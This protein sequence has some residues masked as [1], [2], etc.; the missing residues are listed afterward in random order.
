MFNGENVAFIYDGSFEGFLCCV[1]ES[2]YS[3]CVP[4][5][6]FSE[7]EYEPN[8]WEPYTIVTD[9]KKALKVEN[10]FYKKINSEAATL[11]KTVFLSCMPQK[12]LAILHFLNFAY[13][14]GSKATSLVSHEIVA[15]LWASYRS[16]HNEKHLLLGFVRFTDV[17]EALVAFITPKNYV[18]PFIKEHFCT[19][20]A[21]EQFLIYDKTHKAAL[22]YKNGNAEICDIDSL[23]MPEISA[24]E[25]QF[26]QLWKQFYKTIEIK[27]RHNEKCRMS[28]MPKRY[29][30][31]MIEVA[32][33]LVPNVPL[34]Q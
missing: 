8:L 28:H 17:G 5:A 16:L 6:I 22:I 19:R 34:L 10:S 1:Y 26:R 2:I 30:E 27:A 13:K 3:K 15:P 24:E 23:E 7:A 21:N 31:N 25:E 18:L 32:E 11:V 9:A 33:E 14:T 20:F 12:E 29:W 4:V